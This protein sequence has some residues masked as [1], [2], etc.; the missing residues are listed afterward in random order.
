MDKTNKICIICNSNNSKYKCPI[1]Q[2]FYCSITCFK[3]HKKD[4][5]AK[6]NDND[7]KDEQIETNNIIPLNLDEDEDIIL[8]E[9]QLSVLKKN[10]SIMTKLKN[11]KLKNI[12]KEIDS[13]KYKKRTLEKKM[14]NDPDFK[15]FTTEIL[16]TLGFIKN[17]EFISKEEQN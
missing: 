6:T 5:K 15:E 4:C 7:N 1:C 16:E 12:L 9:K 3:G 2:S 11:K 10:K 13:T 14:E 8:S 17:N